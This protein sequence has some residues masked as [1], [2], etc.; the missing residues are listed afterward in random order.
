MYR[1]F[2]YNSPL[3][4]FDSLNVNTRRYYSTLSSNK[5]NKDDLQIDPWFITGFSDGSN[6]SLVVWGTNLTSTVGT[7]RFTKQITHMIN[8]PFYHFSV[9]VGLVLSDGWL[10]IPRP[11]RKNARF[12]FLQSLD[13]AYYVWFVFN[14]L[15]HY[16]SRY[17][18]L[19]KRSRLGVPSYA[20]EFVT[21]ILPCFTELH[22]LFYLSGRKIIPENIYELLTPVA[23]AHLI[24]GDGSVQR[25]GL[26]IC[27]DS[28]SIEDV[29]RLINVLII[30]YRVECTIRVPKENQYRI[31][32][33]ERSMH[34]IREVV[35][36]HMCSTML[37]KIKL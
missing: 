33:R 24:M 35:E 21:R 11:D 37:F 7:G 27:T 25:H 30:K 32:I 17:P 12:C 26:I 1:K 18:Y 29:V 5:H 15:S 9:M 34:L 36:L 16:C 31:Y 4:G 10:T 3:I 20:L 13:K 19:R 23:L 6:L 22:S 14:I 2:F 8:L 28:Y